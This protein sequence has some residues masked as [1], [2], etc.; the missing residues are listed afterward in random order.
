M[1]Y[2][3][4]LQPYDVA[5]SLGKLVDGLWPDKGEDTGTDWMPPVDICE[6][7]DSIEFKV[8]LPGI[9]RDEIEVEVSNGVLTVRGEKKMQEEK[10]GDTWHRREFS[11]GSFVRSFTLPSD[12]KSEE[13]EASFNEGVLTI[14]IPKEEKALHRK[15]EIKG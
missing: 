9:P 8:E 6:K 15:I 4:Q 10:K 14:S 1:L 2:R 5:Y 3:K 12:M 13:A 11:Y 7:A